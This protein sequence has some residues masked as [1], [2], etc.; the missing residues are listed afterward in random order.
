MV[1]PTASCSLMALRAR[2]AL[3]VGLP[4]SCACLADKW[5]TWRGH[6]KVPGSTSK[7][8]LYSRVSGHWAGERGPARG[9]CSPVSTWPL[10]TA[11]LGF[12]K[13]GAPDNQTPPLAW[14]PWEQLFCVDPPGGSKTSCDLGL[15]A[16][17]RQS[18]ASYSPREGPGLAQT[19]EG[20]TQGRQG[21]RGPAFEVWLGGLQRSCVQKRGD[22]M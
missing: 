3:R 9:G 16:T 10:R 15:E 12:L 21:S 6:L 8:P 17:Q 18:A 22:G 20:A 14:I 1:A 19:Q 7:G 11:V 13:A 5:R 4:C 2:H